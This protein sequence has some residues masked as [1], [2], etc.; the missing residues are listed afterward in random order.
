MQR[1]RFLLAASAAMILSSA[2]GAQA[3]PATPPGVHVMN[4]VFSDA[5]GMSLYTYDR[6]T[7]ANKSACT[8]QCLRNWPAL[9]A[10]DGDKDVGDWKVITRDDGTKAWA[11]KGKPLYYFAQDKAPGDKVGDGRG[12]VWHLAKP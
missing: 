2:V 10:A 8:A 12:G 5:K 3:T 7:V 4:G 11:Y 9:T 6:D 1:L